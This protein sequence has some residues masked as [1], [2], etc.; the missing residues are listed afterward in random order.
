MPEASEK[1]LKTIATHVGV[2]ITRHKIYI[3]DYYANL[4]MK[5]VFAY[6]YKKRLQN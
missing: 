6:A 2:I 3:E 5:Q 1:Y 4:V